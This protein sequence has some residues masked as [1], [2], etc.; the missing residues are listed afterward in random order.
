M[1]LYN[2]KKIILKSYN[3]TNYQIRIKKIFIMFNKDERETK[4]F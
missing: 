2:D 4:I 3:I 1:A